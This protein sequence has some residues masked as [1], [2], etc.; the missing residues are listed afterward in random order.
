MRSM[1]T[2]IN[3][4][5]L[6]LVGSINRPAILTPVCSEPTYFCN[7][8]LGVKGHYV[9]LLLSLKVWSFLC[10]NTWTFSWQQSFLFVD[11]LDQAVS[12]F[13]K[14]NPPIIVPKVKKYL[15]VVTEIRGW[16]DTWTETRDQLLDYQL[17]IGPVVNKNS[18]Q[19][20]IYIYILY[21]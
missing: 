19:Q 5:I 3:S 18:F 20:Y 8:G 17:A 21:I 13:W 11:L 15:P 12:T 9:C 14:Y 7:V 10:Y 16:T 6:L 1:F 2:D 4:A